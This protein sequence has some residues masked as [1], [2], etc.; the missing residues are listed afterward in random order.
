MKL[1]VI[2]LLLFVFL[3]FSAK[4]QTEEPKP[5][6]SPLGLISRRIIPT[7]VC[8]QIILTMILQ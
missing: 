4:S 5:K 3:S 1:S 8:I 6:S 7:E 2:P